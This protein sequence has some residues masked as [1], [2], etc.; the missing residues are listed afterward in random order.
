MKT[1]QCSQASCSGSHQGCGMK[2][3][4]KYLLGIA[5]R[6]GDRGLG[7]LPGQIWEAGSRMQFLLFPNSRLDV[8]K[9]L[10]HRVEVH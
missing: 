8:K 7:S 4:G 1:P 3:G 10:S 6:A 5:G 2:L 9:N